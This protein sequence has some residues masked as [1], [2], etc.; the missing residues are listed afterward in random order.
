M[1]ALLIPALLGCCLSAAHAGNGDPWAKT[2]PGAMPV[3]DR[4]AIEAPIVAGEVA[5]FPVVDRAP[6]GEATTYAAVGEA[7]TRGTLKIDEVGGSGAVG[8]LLVHNFGDEPVLALAGD[9]VFGGNQDRIIAHD[10]I[11]PPHTDDQLISV[12]CV[13]QGRWA[14]SGSFAYGGRAETALA[15][16]VQGK[17]SQEDTWAT[18]AHLNE[19]K[20]TWA[21]SNGQDATSYAP[22]TGTYRA[23]LQRMPE[24]RATA[25]SMM[26]EL[27]RRERVVGIVVAHGGQVVASEL[28][29]HPAQF[30][31]HGEAALVA[32]AVSAVHGSGRGSVPTT[33]HAADFLAASLR[34]LA[35][36]HQAS[37]GRPIAVSSHD[38]DGSF[39]RMASYAP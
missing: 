21:L 35:E 29:V 7:M 13:E 8:Q 6:A 38:A 2:L 27:A 1:R 3:G 24:V 31:R 26:Q 36:P 12:H 34:A 4:L 28:Y 14:S 9:V 16:A 15:R 19:A 22:S 25:L 17:D 20:A 30:A 23:S 33:A 5:V 10:V 37:S 39:V 32:A 11:I 18:V